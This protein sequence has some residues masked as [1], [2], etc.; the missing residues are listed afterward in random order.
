MPDAP[1]LIDRPFWKA[2]EKHFEEIRTRHLRDL[3][4]SDPGRGE[5]LAAQGAGLLLDYSKHRV[6]DETLRLLFA[7]ARDCLY[8]N[9]GTRHIRCYRHRSGFVR[10]R[11]EHLVEIAAECMSA[12]TQ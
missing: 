4:A 3:F 11:D 9:A 6:T 5:R 1:R 10:L 8:A 12:S 7:L 2:L